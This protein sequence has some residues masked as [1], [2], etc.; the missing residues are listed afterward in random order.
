MFSSGTTVIQNFEFPQSAVDNCIS[1]KV[2]VSFSLDKSGKPVNVEILRSTPDGLFDEIS[3]F[4]MQKLSF[5]EADRTELKKRGKIH[6]YVTLQR[7][8]LLSTKPKQIIAVDE[9]RNEALSRYVEQQITRLGW[10][11]NPN[12]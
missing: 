12:K 2:S 8:E 6:I 1:G 10:G 9:Q 11:N 5:D 7:R 4:N 3:V